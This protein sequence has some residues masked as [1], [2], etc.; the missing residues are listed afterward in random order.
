MDRVGIYLM[1][2]FYMLIT[3]YN[4][5]I[6]HRLSCFKGCP[7]NQEKFGEGGVQGTMFDDNKH[8]N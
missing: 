7:G 6:Y 2:L 4:F 1:R 8:K 5:K 3:L